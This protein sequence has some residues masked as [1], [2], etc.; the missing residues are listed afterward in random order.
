MYLE[1]EAIRLWRVGLSQQQ[2]D[3]WNAPTTVMRHYKARLAKDSAATPTLTPA[4]KKDAKIARLQEELDAA[5]TK[6]RRLEKGE[7]DMLLISRQD[8]P[9]AILAGR[10]AG[11]KD[12]PEAILRVLESEIPTKAGRIAALLLN[13]QKST[14][15]RPARGSEGQQFSS[16]TLKPQC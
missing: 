7:G 3:E 1:A 13:R 16:G 2:R 6:I 10:F 5:N 12:T 14:A 8:T 4:A 15:P 11:E 9:E